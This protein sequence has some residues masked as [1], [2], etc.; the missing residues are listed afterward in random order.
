MRKINWSTYYR[1][2]VREKKYEHQLLALEEL[3][4]KAVGCSSTLYAI[5]ETSKALMDKPNSR[6]RITN[7]NLPK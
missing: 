5:A 7:I 4:Q 2:R 1:C 6:V 3:F